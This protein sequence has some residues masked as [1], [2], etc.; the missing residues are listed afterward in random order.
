MSSADSKSTCLITGAAGFIGQALAAAL[1]EDASISK[2]ILTDIVEPPS[3][4]KSNAASETEIQCV[5][6]DLC[7]LG[8]CRELFTP[9]IRCIYML[10][11]IMSGQ[12]EANLDLGMRINIDS[13]RTLFDYL[14]HTNKG[15]TVVFTSSTAV[16]GPP[17]TPEFVFTESTAPDPGSSYGAQKHIC[18]T[19]LNDYSRRG[20]LDARI[21]RLPTVRS[22]PFGWLLSDKYPTGRRETRE[23]DRCSIVF[24]VWHLPRAV[25]G[26][27]SRSPGLERSRYLDLLTQDGCQE[28]PLGAQDPFGALPRLV[29]DCQLARHYGLGAADACC[30]ESCRG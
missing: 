24:R 23:A 3:P 30:F 2:L 4:T 9:D 26:G 16:Y 11:G 28:P 27:T 19:L 20:I 5:R 12:A 6:A 15:V 1:L 25:E 8:T 10:H 14:R 21:C 17:P 13:Y 18:E 29:E 7:D 22:T